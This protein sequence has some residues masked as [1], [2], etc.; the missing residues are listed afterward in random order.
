MTT[1]IERAAMALA[2]A[3]LISALSGCHKEEGPAEHAGKAIDKA[4]ETAGRQVEEAGQ[5]LQEA[6]KGSGK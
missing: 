1:Y 4:M 2:A 5:A 6:S 3:V